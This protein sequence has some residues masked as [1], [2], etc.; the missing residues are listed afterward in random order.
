MFGDIFMLQ[1]DK[2]AIIKDYVE[3]LPSRELYDKYN[4]RLCDLK[5]LLDFYDIEPRSR[6][7]CVQRKQNQEKG[8]SVRCA[9]CNRSFQTL[10]NHLKVHGLTSKEYVERFDKPINTPSR[11]KMLSK[12]H[13]EKFDKHPELREKLRMI[14]SQNIRKVNEKGLGWRMPKGYHTEEHKK[15]MSELLTGRE[16]TWK[17]KIRESHWARSENAQEIID[18]ICAGNKHFKR[19][20]YLSTKTGAIEF[21]HSSYELQRMKELDDDDF[22]VSWTKKHGIA[23]PYLWNDVQRN[24]VPD[25]LIQFRDTTEC[26]EEVKGYVRDIEQHDLKCSVAIDY[27][28]ENNMAYR[29]NFMREHV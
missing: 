7:A 21:Y 6:N 8:E 27:C 16:I 2:E 3:G 13:K 23:I 25:F 5:D 22:V 20:W 9:I 11:K 26:L 19:G 14:G 12:I 28:R 29:V 1:M 17:N 18:K 4:I 15:R 10:S 24:Y